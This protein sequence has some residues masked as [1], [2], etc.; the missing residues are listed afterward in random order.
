MRVLSQAAKI[1]LGTVQLGIPYGVSNPHGKVSQSNAHQLL[2]TALELGID[3]LDTAQSYGDSESVIGEWLEKRPSN[4]KLPKIVTKIIAIPP[5]R[6]AETLQRSLDTLKIN[7]IDAI[8][9]H[10]ED[11]LMGLHGPVVWRSLS[12]LKAAGRISKV[13]VSSY[14]PETLL[15][16]TRRH[17]LD[18]VQIPYNLLDRRFVSPELCQAYRSGDIEV[19]ARSIFLQGLFF[20]NPTTCPPHMTFACSALQKIQTLTAQSGFSAPLL[21]LASAMAHATISKA[22]I[23]VTSAQELQ[24]LTHWSLPPPDLELDQAFQQIGQ[25]CPEVIDPRRWPLIR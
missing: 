1:A 18:I 19:H 21:S 14:S 16:L 12:A 6:I 20:L 11:D 10:Q 13:G 22:V 23:G 2:N 3:T 25:S 4:S 5:E 9:L 24:E 7:Q 8:L 17:E 15:E